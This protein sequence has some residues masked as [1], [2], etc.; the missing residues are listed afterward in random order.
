VVG[1]KVLAFNCSPKKDEGNTAL[2]LN[3]LLEGIKEAG[4]EAELIY[5]K[6]LKVRPCLACFNCC[7][8]TLGE[9]TQKDDMQDIYPKLREADTW[10]LGTPVWWGGVPGPAKNLIDRFMPLIEPFSEERDGRC[11][12]VRREGSSF[13]RLALVSSCFGWKTERFDSL[14][15]Q[16]EELAW[17]LKGQLA[18]T[19]LRPHA[20]ALPPMV[21]MN[22]PLDDIF[23]AAKE[24]GR[25][26]VSDGKISEETSAAVARELMPMDAYIQAGNQA[27]QQMLDEAR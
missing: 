19:L 15:A 11:E 14:V 9:C 25:Q 22:V 17:E 23:E 12:M 10:V 7:F 4:A 8:K 3:P 18:G 1:L 20:D 13:E 26:L 2:I 16:I 24:A 5:M 27:I 6:D 21:E